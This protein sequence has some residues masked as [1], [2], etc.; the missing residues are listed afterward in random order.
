MNADEYAKL[1][2][3]EQ[4][5]WFYRGK[6][7]IVRYWIDRYLALRPDDVLVDGGTGTGT[8]PVE[9]SGRCR[10]IGLDQHDDSIAI[11]RAPLEKVG[12][13]M[14]QTSLDRV[15]LPDGVAAVVTLLDVLEHLDDDMAA[16]REMIRLVRP[17]GLVVITVPALRW[18]WSDWDVVLHHRRRYHQ[19]YLLRLVRQPGVEVLHCGYINSVA[20]LPILL[21]RGWRRWFPPK[22]GA[23][24]AEDRIPWG[25]VNSLLYSLFVV[26]ARWRW[27]RPPAGVSLLAV[28]RKKV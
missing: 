11:A 4:R 16:L 27:F 24:R 18:L 13:R 7:A 19:T 14:L 8:W 23:A 21:I 3:V 15:D 10:V 25:P 2:Q 9:M 5:H 6:R 22:P 1:E 28:L 26:P 17:G 12:G 20:L